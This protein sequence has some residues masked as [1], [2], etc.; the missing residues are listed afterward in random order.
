MPI[1]WELPVM[2]I[3]TSLILYSFFWNATTFSYHRRCHLHGVL[4]IIEDATAN[5]LKALIYHRRCHGNAVTAL[6]C[7]CRRPASI[8]PSWYLRRR[9][10]RI[11]SQVYKITFFPEMSESRRIT[12]PDINHSYMSLTWNISLACIYWRSSPQ[13]YSV[14]SLKRHSWIDWFT[15]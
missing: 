4:A 6:S 9:T 7:P 10:L 12:L 3:H 13:F 11:T 8:S 1:R 2:C 5:D 14:G 15:S